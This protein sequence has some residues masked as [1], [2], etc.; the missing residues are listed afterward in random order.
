M[1]N[2]VAQSSNGRVWFDSNTG[3]VTLI[4]EDPGCENSLSMIDSIDV[5]KLRGVYPEG[6]PSEVDILECGYWTKDGIY[7]PPLWWNGTDFIRT[8]EE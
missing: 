5:V 4:A 8:G 3:T 6:I 2:V 1:M 7:E